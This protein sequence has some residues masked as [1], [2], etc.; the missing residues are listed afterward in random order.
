MMILIVKVVPN[1][2]ANSIEK[3]K[4]GSLKV[5]IKAPP[6]KGKAN[7]ELID[8]LAETFGIPKREIHLISGQTSR[9]KKIKIDREI[10]F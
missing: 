8:F 1:A 10:N 6:D 3:M 4:D 2:R 9:L 5:R 7:D